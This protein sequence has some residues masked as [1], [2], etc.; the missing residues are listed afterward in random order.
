MKLP[1]DVKNCSSIEV[2]GWGYYEEDIYHQLF[3]T[4]EFFKDELELLEKVN[5]MS[6]ERMFEPLDL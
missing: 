5:A 6:G 1:A 2:P 4:E 3:S